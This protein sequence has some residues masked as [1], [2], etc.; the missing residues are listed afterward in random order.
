[1]PVE[2]GIWKISGTLQRI[3]F[4]AMGA[5]EHLEGVLE[6]DITI[7]DST[8]MVVGRQVVTG[9][10]K[11]ID[12]LAINR[13]GDISIIELKRHK[14]PREVVAQILD[15]A[16]WVQNLSY[17]EIIGIFEKYKP[18]KHLEEAFTERFGMNLPDSINR[19]HRLIIVAAELD[20]GTERI[21]A[22]LSNRYG[23]PINAVFFRYFQLENGGY[24]ARMWLIDPNQVEANTDQLASSRSGKEPWNGQDYYVVLGEGVHRTWEDCLRYGFISA[25]QGRWYSRTLEQ[26]TPGSRIF[27]HIPQQGYVGVGIVK[28]M[29]VP[30]KDFH[31]VVNGKEMSILDAPKKTT[32]MEENAD[33]PEKSEYLVRIDWI[34]TIPIGGKPIWKKGMFTNQNT[35]CKLR[36]KF[37]LD[38]LI[39][40]F[41]L[42]G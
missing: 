19:E 31:V 3:S 18:G 10:K 22:Y 28:E 30:V 27:V 9:F 24:L 34:N 1:M 33:D 23:V 25:G 2:V 11:E 32:Y 12:L 29:V 20:S 36:S 41:G 16:S 14:T 39:E 6:Q 15:Y 4:Q 7:L 40:Q 8:L 42:E 37:T 26:L 5:E 38:T 35:V 21:I 13:E 17:E